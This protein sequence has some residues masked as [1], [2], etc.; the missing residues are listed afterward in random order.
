MFLLVTSV[1]VLFRVYIYFIY[2]SVSHLVKVK[3][4]HTLSQT[5]LAKIFLTSLIGAEG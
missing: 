5:N 4:E 1:T 2:L 3:Y